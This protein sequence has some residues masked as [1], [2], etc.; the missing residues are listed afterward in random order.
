LGRFRSP[1]RVLSIYLSFE[2]SGGE[3]RDIHAALEDALVSLEG[4]SLDERSRARLAEEGE[5]AKAYL[6]RGFA[7]HGRS[8]IIFSCKPRKLWEV[9]Q[10]QVPVHPLARFSD[11]PAVAPLAALLDAHERYAVVLADK[12]RARI[13]HVYLGQVEHEIDVADGYPGRSRKGGWSEARYSRHRETHLHAH[14]LRAMEQLLD[15]ERRHP[16]DR[17]VVGGPDEARSAFLAV[18]PRSLRSRVAGTFAAEQ[19]RSDF[20]VVERVRAIEETAHGK[21]KVHEVSDLLDTARAGGPAVLGWDETLQ[22]LGEGRVHRLV[23]VD[24]AAQAGRTCAAGH[25][26]CVE[27]LSACPLCGKPLEAAI[28]L[29]EWAVRRALDTDATIESVQGEAADAL[30]TGGAIGALLRY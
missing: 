18:L 3:R 2:P 5:L 8:V 1:Q 15:E 30:A 17:L 24:G 29:Q 6:Q 11:R 9:F 21:A 12:D 28:D 13:L 20:D 14:L 10:L 27:S 4:Q 16:F 19:F 23:L 22:A 7:L 26:A 25:F